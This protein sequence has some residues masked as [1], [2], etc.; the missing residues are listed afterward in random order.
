MKPY[1][2]LL[3]DDL[4]IYEAVWA[5]EQALRRAYNIP[6]WV[7]D[8]VIRS[9]TYWV[10]NCPTCPHMMVRDGSGN[11]IWAIDALIDYIFEEYL[12]D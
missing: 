8:E 2:D 4:E 1:Y 3:G 5:T 11:P 9:Y 10:V 12:E 6:E 7:D